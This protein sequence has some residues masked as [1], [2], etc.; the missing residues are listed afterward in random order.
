LPRFANRVRHIV[1][2]DEGSGPV[3][4]GCCVFH[5]GSDYFGTA[6]AALANRRSRVMKSFACLMTQFVGLFR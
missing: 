1:F 2:L 3:K 4:L 6:L 5:H